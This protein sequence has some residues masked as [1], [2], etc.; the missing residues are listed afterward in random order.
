MRATP[1][2][3][4]DHGTVSIYFEN[5]LFVGTDRYYTNG[6]KLSWTSPALEKFADTKYIKPVLPLLDLVPFINAPGFQRNVAF[7]LGQ[8]I[9]TPDSTEATELLENDRPYAGWLYVGLGLVWK[10]A[11]VRN[12]VMLNVGVVG[13]WSLAEETQRKVHE[14]RGI[15]VPKGWDNQL[16]NE[17]GVVVTYE[18]SWRWPYRER[19][20]GFNW[21]LIPHAGAAAG[22]VSIFANAGAE[23]R[24]GINMPDDFGTAPIGPAVAT[25]TPVE[26]PDRAERPRVFDLGAYVFARADGRVIARNIFLDGNTFEGSASVDKK[27]L[28]AD[29]SLGASMNYK[30]T[31]VTYALV[32]RTKEF[33]GQEEGQLFGSVTLQFAF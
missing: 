13:P 10:N 22:N 18:R 3:E 28:V 29:L 27:P 4:I 14:M 11:Q 8:N 12:S 2:D 19:R 1:V 20:A 24:A 21:E 25:G 30:Q 23:L 26:G 31:K 5:D 16:G 33:D 9:Y 32:Y 17:L 7:S 6:V 15:D